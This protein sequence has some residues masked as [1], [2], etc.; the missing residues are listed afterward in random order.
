MKRILKLVSIGACILTLASLAVGQETRVF[1]EGGNWVQEITGN[2]GAARTLRVKVDM[3]SV[4]VEGGAQSAVSYVI[5]S[6]SYSS[7]EQQARRDFELYKISA[8]SKGDAA[9]IVGDWQG[10]RHQDRKFSGEFVIMVPRSLELAKI[11]TDGGSVRAT[12]ISGRTEIQ[13]GGGSIHVDDVS[14][15]VDA[16]TGGG[17]IDIGTTGSDV[18]VRTGGGNIKIASAKGKL[19]AES[20][21]GSIAV[22]SC[23]QGA[24]LDTGGGNI[25][26]DRCQGTVH[27]TTGGGSVELGDIGG[28]VQME[29]GGGSIR[30][31]SA[32]GPVKAET[33][34]GCIELNGVP[35]ARA[36]TGGGGIIARFL[37]SSSADRTDSA[38][39]TSAG[40]ITVYLASDLAISIRANIE[41]ANGH[42]IVS[43]FSDI[44]IASEGG[45]WG[46][47]TVSAEGQLNGGGPVLKV[48]TNSGNIKFV[49]ASR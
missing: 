10:G 44:H 12:G 11:E 22:V 5:R 33:G 28:P 21:G 26:V 19:N 14:G 6:R 43:D 8:Y 13:S 3:G 36:E 4:R 39:E 34:G 41:L 30:L 18:N 45:D 46:P 32:T 27:A 35:S 47:R 48:R 9:W 29:T 49:R 37:N 24:T 38:L 20:G 17:T 23:L 15:L 16:E 7:S 2:L 31:T 1:R 42:K 40:D 25:Q